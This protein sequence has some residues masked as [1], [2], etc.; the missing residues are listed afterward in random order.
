MQVPKFINRII[1]E[2]NIIEKISLEENIDII[3]SDNRFGLR[4][5]S[6]TNI[7][8]THQL[9][10]MGPLLVTKLINVINRKIIKNFD[11]I[12]IPDFENGKLSG[13]LSKNKMKCLNIGPLSRFE[14]YK[15]DDSKIL[16]KYLAIISGPE[17][18]RSLLEEEIT[19]CFLQ[20]NYQC[21]IINGKTK[22]NKKLIENI[23]IF[24]HLEIK[25]FTKLISSSELIICRSGYSSIM[26]LYYLQ[27]KVMFIPTPGQTEQEYLAK[28]YK[29]KYSISFFKQGEIDLKKQ[30]FNSIKKIPNPKKKLL[31]VAFEKVNL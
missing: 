16:Y 18:H 13:E 4:S 15:N 23:S 22:E 5:K 14:K 20:S 12:W 26:D 31:K 1:K 19:S 6:A 8:I 29:K 25:D 3:I 17:P 7:F 28:Y 9:N 21:A 10:I 30:N 27:K 24:S 11:H 2:K